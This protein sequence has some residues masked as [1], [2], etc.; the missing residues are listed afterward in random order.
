MRQRV[1]ASHF[2]RDRQ[3][4]QR[5]RTGRL[6]TLRFGVFRGRAKLLHDNRH[7]TA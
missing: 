3:I 4:R 6:E 5:E 7:D 2:R 1:G